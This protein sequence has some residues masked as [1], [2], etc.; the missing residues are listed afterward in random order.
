M[1]VCGVSKADKY[2]FH[3]VRDKMSFTVIA[4]M[5]KV[6]NMFR[7]RSKII[8]EAKAN[9]EAIMDTL[10]G[11]IPGIVGFSPDSSKEARANAVAPQIEGGTYGLDPLVFKEY[12]DEITFVKEWTTFQTLPT[13][14]GCDILPNSYLILM[15]RIHGLISLPR[16]I[17][18]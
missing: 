4:E 6:A 2:L 18:G 10:K 3:I 12:K 14:T 16:V 1:E 9:G 7:D 11:K 15:L 5:T 13:M 8:V 17:M